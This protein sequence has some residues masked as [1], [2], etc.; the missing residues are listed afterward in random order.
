M[1]SSSLLQR[2]QKFVG[3]ELR[4]DCKQRKKGVSSAV[5]PCSVSK[6]SSAKSDASDG[7]TATCDTAE[8]GEPLS[9]GFLVDDAHAAIVGLYEKWIEA[10]QPFEQ[11][12]QGSA[13]VVYR[14]RRKADEQ[15]VAVKIMRMHDDDEDHLTASQKEFDILKS[16]QHPCI[17]KALDFIKFPMGAALVMEYF[18]G[19]NLKSAV[20][21]VLGKRMQ[22]P[23]A[24]VI[25]S[26]LIQA[27]A[28]L[29]KN[30]II[31]RDVKA[32]NVLVSPQF[33]NLRLIDFNVAKSMDDG[34][35]TMTGTVDWMPPEV[36]LG[37]SPTA[38][39]DIW[40][41]GMCLYLM[42]CGKMPL[43][44]KNFRSKY[45]SGIELSAGDLVEL[46]LSVSGNVSGACKAVLRSCLKPDPR[47]RAS[48]F[49]LLGQQWIQ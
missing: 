24:Q 43:E 3:S 34:P 14:A 45:E 17:I 10:Y 40:A 28:Y 25:F 39:G 7:S 26:K 23:V 19:F 48:A 37:D 6:V 36:L 5:T 16:L 41:A 49:E 29:H 35:L 18:P 2:R 42:L 30:E 1:E 9:G 31:H 13:G 46:P 47:K 12:G 15:N 32:Q 20:R 8:S 4:I 38:A 11:L 27:I 44:G 33:D 21:L 22:E